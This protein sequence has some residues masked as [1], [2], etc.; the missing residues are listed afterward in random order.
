MNV[1]VFVGFSLIHLIVQRQGER[2]SLVA[3]TIY[4]IPSSAFCSDTSTSDS[5]RSDSCG[6]CAA[7]RP[8][9][10]RNADTTHEFLTIT[11]RSQTR[12]NKVVIVI[13]SEHSILFAQSRYKMNEVCSKNLQLSQYS[14]LFSSQSL[15]GQRQ[16]PPGAEQHG[17]GHR[18]S[19]AH[20][21]PSV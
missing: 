1:L 9:P 5:R 2:G 18:G 16:Q 17:A 10:C 4:F 12:E 19:A 21:S 15:P 6:S 14:L 20:A 13:S 11:R 3:R 8:F 7:S